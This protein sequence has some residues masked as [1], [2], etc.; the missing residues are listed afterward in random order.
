M[1][2]INLKNSI[3][4][5]VISFNKTCANSTK[6]EISELYNVNNLTLELNSLKLKLKN[7]Q[8]TNIE[9]P[10]ITNM[11]ILHKTLGLG[12]ITKYTLRNGKIHHIW[13]KFADRE[14]YFP[15]SAVNNFFTINNPSFNNSYTKQLELETEIED[16]KSHIQILEAMVSKL[17][18]LLKK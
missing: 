8:N 1:N 15:L 5:L 7:L 6:Q 16:L 3:T 17:K 10:N 14:T 9:F 4:A 13:V 18:H 11:E 12:S 2:N